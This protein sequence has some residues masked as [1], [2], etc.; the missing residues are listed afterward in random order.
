MKRFYRDTLKGFDAES[1]EQIRLWL[2]D[3]CYDLIDS[4]IC[5]GMN[6]TQKD[7][8]HLFQ[9]KAHDLGY[10]GNPWII[11]YIMDLELTLHTGD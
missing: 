4:Y 8:I 11:V 3:P 1:I 2:K 6:K 5:E 9:D 10:E 7:F